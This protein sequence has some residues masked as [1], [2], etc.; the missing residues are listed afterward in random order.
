MSKLFKIALFLVVFLPL[1]TFAQ[2]GKIVGKV[3]DLETGEI[4][5]GANVIV[6]GTQL[7]AA[8]DLNGEVFYT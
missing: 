1:I 4:L 7:G 5:I 6:G 8:T 2:T 3:I